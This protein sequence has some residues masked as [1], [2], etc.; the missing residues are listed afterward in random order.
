MKRDGNVIMLVLIVSAVC[1]TTIAFA[2][3]SVLIQ[4]RLVL[5]RRDNIQAEL[6]L[7]RIVAELV[8][9]S[10]DA[11]NL[12]KD[13]I[14]SNKLETYKPSNFPLSIDGMQNTSGIIDFT[15]CDEGSI[16]YT[17]TVNGLRNGVQDSIIATGHVYNPVIDHC[18]NGLVTLQGKSLEESEEINM[19]LSEMKQTFEEKEI[20]SDYF[21]AHNYLENEVEIRA[22]SS[23]YRYIDF[24]RGDHISKYSFWN[25]KLVLFKEFDGFNRDIIRLEEQ[26]GS[27]TYGYIMGII[28]IEEGDLII[29]GDM[30]IFGIVIIENGKLI[31][32]GDGEV[33][34]K[35]KVI[36][37][38]FN[39][40]GEGIEIVY[41]QEY[42]RLM[43]R[44]LPG[45][46]SPGIDSIR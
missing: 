41:D 42:V 26:S 20:T 8:I 14:S 15:E 34:I 27:L 28:Y 38:N 1:M 7:E 13:I 35:G 46:I 2:M 3:E 23:G 44:F 18:E 30:R 32:E 16:N 24:I 21:L 19:F 10:G 11:Q 5:N 6:S 33:L 9:E 22:K 36:M 45:F 37:D 12:V 40:P 25:G 4:N 29:S 31:K 39:Q 17:M 43:A